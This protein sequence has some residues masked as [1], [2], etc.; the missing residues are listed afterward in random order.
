MR[1]FYTF[2]LLQLLWFYSLTILTDTQPF[3][4]F[5]YHVLNRERT[6]SDIILSFLIYDTFVKNLLIFFFFSNQL[7]PV[8]AAFGVPPF[9][10]LER[11]AAPYFGIKV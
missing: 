11:A 9:F 2:F 1:Y 7:Y 5:G 4:E 6:F 8:T 3:A 10:S